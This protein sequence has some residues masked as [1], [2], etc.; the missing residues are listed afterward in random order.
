M[1]ITE[2]YI[3]IAAKDITSQWIRQLAERLELGDDDPTAQ[4]EDGTPVY[5]DLHDEPYYVAHGQAYE[6][7]PDDVIV[8]PIDQ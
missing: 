7:D 5:F 1:Q 4:L 2:N 6:L 8:F 3:R